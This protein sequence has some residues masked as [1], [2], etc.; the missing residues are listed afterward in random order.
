MCYA[1]CILFECPPTAKYKVLQY[2][3]YA[4]FPLNNADERSKI[5]KLA[6]VVNAT[7]YNYFW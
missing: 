2:L 1:G 6:P 4:G 5:T 3:A 7:H